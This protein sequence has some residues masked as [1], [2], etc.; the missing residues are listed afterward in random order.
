MPFID[1]PELAGVLGEAPATEHRA[2]TGLLADRI[3]GRVSH[4]TASTVE[5]R[6][7][8]TASGIGEVAG[9]L[10]FA[11]PSDFVRAGKRPVAARS[12]NGSVGKALL[13]S[14]DYTGGPVGVFGVLYPVGP[15]PLP[16]ACRS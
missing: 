16:I 15:Q 6:Y 4:G 3:V 1:A 10:S 13:R 14:S 5:Q 2:L 11:T 7:Y 12:Q 8:P 9:F